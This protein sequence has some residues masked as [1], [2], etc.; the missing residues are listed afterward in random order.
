EGAGA[1]EVCGTVPVP[2]DWAPGAYLDV[3]E[4][5]GLKR[6]FR[7]LVD[8]VEGC[9]EVDAA[10][11]LVDP[12][13]RRFRVTAQTSSRATALR[14]DAPDGTAISAGLDGTTAQDG[15]QVTAQ[16]DDDYVTFEVSLPPGKGAGN[17]GFITDPVTTAADRQMCVFHDLHFALA[18]PNQQ[19]AAGLTDK[20]MVA[21]VGPDGVATDLTL[22]QNAAVG[23]SA[24]GP[25][26]QP[27]KA[28]AAIEGG[29]VAVQIESRPTDARIE[30]SL[31]LD[32]TTQ[33]GLA[34][35][36]LSG[37][38]ALVL[39][40]SKEFPIV[41]PSDV[42]DLG[43][44]EKVKTA[45]ATVSLT[46]SSE[47]PTKVCFEPFVDVRVPQEAAGT[48]PVISET[49][50]ELQTGASAQVTVSVT[51]NKAAEGAGAARLPVVLHSA[52]T[53]DR[54]S[55]E[56]RYEIPVEWRFSDPLNA[57]VAILVLLIVAALSVLLPLAA[58]G[59]ANIVTAKFETSGL[60]VG[61]VPIVITDGVPKRAEGAEDRGGRL[62][63]VFLDQDVAAIT[64]P[65]RNRRKFSVLNIGFR[66]RGTLNPFGVPTFRAI[67]PAGHKIMSSVH[68]PIRGDREADVSP[69]LG[70]V[71]LVVAADS[72][73]AKPG[74]G[75]RAELIFLR[76]GAPAEFVD[77][78]YAH[79]LTMRN[80][81]WYRISDVWQRESDS[82]LDP[83]DPVDQPPDASDG[84]QSLPSN[85]L[86]D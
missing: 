72:E 15:Y 78:S 8:L 81:D 7:S 9:A 4:P 74:R 56:A 11:G 28:A 10:T 53:A 19:L 59:L 26:G 85:P 77:S 76:R 69:G 62:L 65:I 45:S 66:A 54:P 35:A 67:A 17:W 55:Q 52:A 64:G 49:C 41:S 20:V 61:R 47:G 14:L 79:R 51:P 29:Q 32:L 83:A 27:L 37:Q 57:P 68:G 86:F 50:V 70:F 63:D 60:T 40:L 25:D 24:I 44:A 16:S 80:I 58:M 21:A 13:V 48:Q 33:S 23:A 2:T 18:D 36:P 22:F 1:G 84:N 46:G 34:L 75:V 71:A 6:I 82:Y 73:L 43:T 30:L 3:G 12:G 5:A 42:I 38:F 39:A 31:K